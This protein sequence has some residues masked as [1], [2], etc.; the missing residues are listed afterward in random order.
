MTKAVLMGD[1][2]SHGGAMTS[3][4]TSLTDG[5]IGVCR[6]GDMYSCPLHGENSIIDGCTS[7]LLN[8]GIEVALD[9]AKTGCGASITGTGTLTNG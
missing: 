2:G 9:G 3:A 4:S 5:G 7:T 8:E 1:V 6:M